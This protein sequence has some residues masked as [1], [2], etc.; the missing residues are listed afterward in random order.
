MSVRMADAAR[1]DDRW[2]D[3][4]RWA[5]SRI[6]AGDIADF[7]ARDR[8]ANPAFEDLDPKGAKGWSDK[9]RLSVSFLQTILTKKPFVEATPVQGVRILGALVDGDDALDLAYVR[10]ERVF[11][12]EKSRLLVDIKCR[13]LRVDDELSLEGSHVTGTVSLGAARIDGK[14]S[15]AQTSCK[16]DVVLRGAKMGGQLQMSGSTFDGTLNIN[17]TKVDRDLFMAKATFEE[18]DLTGAKIGGQ[19]SMSG[20]TFND[21][22][23][24]DS[25]EVGQSLFMRENATFKK[26][27]LRGAK[28][29]GQLSMS[30]STFD[31]PLSMDSIEVCAGVLARS[32]VFISDAD[33]I[34][35]FSTIDSNLDLSGAKIKAID[36]TGTTIKGELRLG[37]GKHPA[38]TWIEPS[39]M[40]LRNTTV[41]VIQDADEDPKRWPRSL[42][43]EGFSYGR[44][45]GFGS[46]GRAAMGTRP[47]AWFE[48]WLERDETYAP[49]PYER[50]A[51]VLRRSGYPI[52][53]DDVLYAGRTRAR[54]QARKEGAWTRWIG[55]WLLQLAIGYG[56]GRRYFRAG[57]WALLFTAI[58]MVVLME[59]LP[60][61]VLDCSLCRNAEQTGHAGEVFSGLN[62]EVPSL[63]PLTVVD[64]FWVSLDQILPIVSLDKENEKLI[65]A[66]WL[67]G[68]AL[69]WFYV[70]K[71]IGWVLGS[72]LVAGLAGLTQKN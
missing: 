12:L 65:T 51:D 48:S 70:Q 56:L 15:L 68:W 17:G 11:W 47:S 66:N 20:S 49:Q 41:G 33:V 57:L 8:E 21:T 50:L 9:R 1:G 10:L 59:S 54:R 61:D 58:G 44:L 55:L 16:S 22:L 19:L 43:M 27:V 31:G 30:G 64:L 62:A 72:F 7:N 29:G 39:K 38:T 46:E 69:Y 67:P 35:R 63:R 60:A 18:V 4:E 52:K 37:S 23:T 45:G 3:A 34:V 24:M 53:S 13:N 26:V 14:V 6:R 32:T 28:I 36:L 25:T 5:W 42:E 71:L 2:S 40:V